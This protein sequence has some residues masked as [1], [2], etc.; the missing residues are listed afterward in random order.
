M[1]SLADR[2]IAALR[3]AHDELAGIVPGL[4]DED[5][6]RTS[7]ASEWTVSQVLSHLGSGAEIG[8]A[9][10]VAAVAGED[11][12]GQDYNQQV[13][14]RWNALAPQEQAAG[15]LEHNEAQ[16][17]WLEDLSPED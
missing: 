10:Y 17:R 6:A 9:G 14:D 2:T 3:N 16:V 4:S 1:T 13:W 11:A 7:G 12:P 5:L 15:F 8:L